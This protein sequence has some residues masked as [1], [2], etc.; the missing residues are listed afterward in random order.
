M[1]QGGDRL[2]IHVEA[3]N[4]LRV[5]GDGLVDDLDGHVAFDAGLEGPEDGPG[6]SGVDLLQEPVAAERLSPQI[7]SGILLQDALVKPDE[8]WEGSMPSSSARISL[9]RW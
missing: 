4:E 8:L 2:G 6:G 9:T 5:G 7:Q 1:L 3:T